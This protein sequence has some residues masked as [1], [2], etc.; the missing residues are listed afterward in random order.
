MEEINI[1]KLQALH[2]ILEAC[3][4][5]FNE[6][7]KNLLA[8]QAKTHFAFYCMTMTSHLIFE[9]NPNFQSSPSKII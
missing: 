6:T 3:P 5:D 4:F 8:M 1:S 2:V 7:F 9:I